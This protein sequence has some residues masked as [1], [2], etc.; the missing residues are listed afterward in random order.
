[1]LPLGRHTARGGGSSVGFGMALVMNGDQ[2]IRLFT[3][4]AENASGPVI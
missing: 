1:M 4:R 2:R 3:A